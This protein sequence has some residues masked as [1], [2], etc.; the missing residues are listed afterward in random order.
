MLAASGGAALVPPAGEHL[1][2]GEDVG[3]RRRVAVLAVLSLFLVGVL[4]AVSADA[5]FSVS[6]PLTSMKVSTLTVSPATNVSAGLASCSNN[7]WIAITVSWSASR[8]AGVTGYLVNAHRN[9]GSTMTVAQTSADTTT[10]DTTVDKLSTGATTVTFTVITQTSYG[11]TAES[12]S[13]GP[14][15]C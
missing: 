11:W 6:R 2:G 4:P 10:A 13:S 3:R 5:A 14:A 9:D 1:G 12:A 7:R 15:T 8:T